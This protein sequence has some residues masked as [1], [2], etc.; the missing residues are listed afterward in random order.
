MVKDDMGQKM[1][2]FKIIIFFLGEDKE[3][4]LQAQ[5]IT[6]VVIVSSDYT[7]TIKALLSQDFYFYIDVISNQYLLGEELA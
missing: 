4:L 6:I 2:H 5:L 1:D 3:A 7:M